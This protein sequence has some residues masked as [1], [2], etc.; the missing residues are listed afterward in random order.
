MSATPTDRTLVVRDGEATG[1]WFLNDYVEMLVTGEETEGRY[2]QFEVHAPPG[3]QPPLH[4]HREADEALH[5]L[6][7]ELEVWAGP[8]HATLRPGDYVLMPK[9][10]PHCY[11]VTS[12]EPAHFVVTVTPAG[13]D[14]FVRGVSRPAEEARIPDPPPPPTPADV[15]R[16]NALMAEIDLEALGPPGARP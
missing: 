1:Y 16:M 4:L 9:G 2:T 3:D 10:V 7:G 6:R 15:E 13:F 14:Q 12:S 11:L 5:L 8:F